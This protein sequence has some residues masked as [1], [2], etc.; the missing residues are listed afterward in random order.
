MENKH[1]KLGLVLMTLTLLL[2]MALGPMAPGLA[3][4]VAE[5]QVGEVEVW[6]GLHGLLAPVVG[7]GSGGG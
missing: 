6:D 5:P 3:A 7:G 4:R 1:S 2:V